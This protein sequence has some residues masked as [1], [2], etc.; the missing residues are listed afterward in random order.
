MFRFKPI[1]SLCFGSS[2]FA[3]NYA[4]IKFATFNMKDAQVNSNDLPISIRLLLLNEPRFESVKFYHQD[5]EGFH[6]QCFADNRAVIGDFKKEN[7]HFG[8]TLKHELGHILHQDG[9][10]QSALTSLSFGIGYG[11]FRGFKH[12]PYLR[13]LAIPITLAISEPIGLIYSQICEKRA[14][15]YAIEK[16]TNQ[17]LLEAAQHYL[18]RTVLLMPTLWQILNDSHDRDIVR[19][20]RISKGLAARK[21]TKVLTL[22][23]KIGQLD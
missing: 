12:R 13:Y 4:F 23:I 2:V 9:L 18:D 14:D 15:N 5:N 20:N 17:E 21:V 22:D 7:E 8:F 11:F 10:K 1:A 16:S 3:F 19:L 6:A